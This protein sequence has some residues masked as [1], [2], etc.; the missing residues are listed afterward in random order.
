MT[1]YGSTVSGF[2]NETCLHICW[3]TQMWVGEQQFCMCSLEQKKDGEK[4]WG[5]TFSKCDF[6]KSKATNQSR[7]TN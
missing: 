4:D 2:H 7:L 1:K 3:E 5:S 6:T